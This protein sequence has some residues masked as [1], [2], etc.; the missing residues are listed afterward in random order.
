[1]INYLIFDGNYILHKCV[2]ALKNTDRF[3]SG[4]YRLMELTMEKYIK[5]NNWDKI[6]FVSDTRKKSWRTNYI[7]NY[8][9][10]RVKDDSIDWD[11]V[12]ET[13]IDFKKD[14]AD[15]YFL[16]EEDHIE[17][18][19]WILFCSRYANKWEWVVV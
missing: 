18:D 1:M 16:L 10:T 19:D 12:Y 2:Q 9:G 4:L 7:D 5:L 17:G 15:K 14:I 13:Y 3:Y 6:I 8:K 11:F